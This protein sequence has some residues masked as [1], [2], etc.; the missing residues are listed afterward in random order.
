VSAGVAPAAILLPQ[1]ISAIA[2]QLGVLRAGGFFVAL[3][4]RQP[5]ARL[6]ATIAHCGATTLLTDAKFFTLAE[7]IAPPGAVVFDVEAI[8]DRRI[9]G[10]F[11][12]SSG[13][14]R[15]RMSITLWFKPAHR[16]AS[17][18]PIGTCCTTFCA[19]RQ[20]SRSMPTI[21]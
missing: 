9:E 5:E 12:A 16:K 3:D 14:T 2:A 21:G 20:A 7:T 6:A 10:N 19:T 1:G 18:I 8:G 11:R 17:R 15:W 4:A 13:R